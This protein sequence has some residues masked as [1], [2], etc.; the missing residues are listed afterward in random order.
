M[1]AIAGLSQPL[2]TRV[3]RSDV[4]RM[5][6]R[7]THCGPD[8]F[9]IWCDQHVGLGHRMWHTTPESLHERLPLFK[10]ATAV[11]ITCDARI[12]NR[13]ELIHACGLSGPEADFADS[14]LILAAYERWGESCVERLLGDFSFAIWDAKKQHIFCARD[15]LGIKPFFYY[16]SGE[17]F[18][19][20]TEIKA[21]L[22]LPRVPRSLNES[23]IAH[24]LLGFFEDRAS[25]F[26]DGI[27]RLPPG[28]SL[29]MRPHS[30]EV[31][32]YWKAGVPAEIRRSSD[33]QYAEEF[34]AIFSEAVHC[35]LRSVPPVGALL[36]GGLD[37][38]SI[39]CLARNQLQADGR[40]GSLHT[41]SALFSGFSESDERLY[42][43]SV[44]QGGG[45]I[46]HFFA[47]ET[48][49]PLTNLGTVLGDL[50]EAFHGGGLTLMRMFF[51]SAK[52][53]GVRV[54][55]DGLGG[56]EVIAYGT[57]YLGELLRTG[58]WPGFGR[59]ASS[60]AETQKADHR[61][62]FRE[63]LQ[64]Y[65]VQLKQQ[66]QFWTLG[67]ALLRIPK[68][69]NE[70]VPRFVGDYALRP[71]ADKWKRRFG[72]GPQRDQAPA[73]AQESLLDEDFAL[74]I[75]LQERRLRAR[76]SDAAL[77]RTAR[78]EHCHR[79]NSG[80]LWLA[81]EELGRAAAP[82]GVEPRYPLLDKRLVEFSLALPL[83]QKL[84]QGWNRAILR[85]AMNQVLPEQVRWRTGKAVFLSPFADALRT[86][87][88]DFLDEAILN[89]P[90][91]LTHYLNVPFLRATYQR[92]LAGDAPAAIDV[93]RA[94]NLIWWLESSKLSCSAGKEPSHLY[95]AQA[96]AG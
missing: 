91:S 16:H 21:L 11:A 92:F 36:S 53:E 12:D 35:R 96:T 61:S 46:P 55:L 25:T 17:C 2:G 19:F 82:Y 59:Q 81:I 20:A 14:E 38:S 51:A 72:L 10:P 32:E 18:A 65:F 42:I 90:S 87:G 26:F 48:V 80:R 6:D 33:A 50:D 43:D 34:L 41:F 9:G 8:G 49:N 75:G 1:S 67:K 28:H 60:L 47:G 54:M 29:T 74:S 27:L 63:H 39:A 24:H 71:L 57:R 5:L 83:S 62:L 44:L 40:K 37:S 13:R 7:L 77:G 88:R 23:R 69:L 76:I 89:T 58:D 64:P 31:R 45:F 30:L 4:G 86:Y 66:R 68:E 94:S 78:E 3:D 70:P 95:E 85:R 93:W 73:P 84:S 79:I 52:Q 56:D 22:A 15:H